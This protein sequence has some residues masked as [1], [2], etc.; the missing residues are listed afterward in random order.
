MRLLGAATVLMGYFTPAAA[1]DSQKNFEIAASRV[2]AM[3][4]TKGSRLRLTRANMAF[5][6]ASSKASNFK[7][8]GYQSR[9]LLK[10]R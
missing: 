1:E 7:R 8:I 4:L 10:F 2:R 6:G 3:T 5:V 9:E